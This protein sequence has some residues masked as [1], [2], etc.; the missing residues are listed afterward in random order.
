MNDF[1]QKVSE[2]LYTLREGEVLEQKN[3]TQYGK[4]MGKKMDAEFCMKMH[5]KQH[6]LAIDHIRQCYKSSICLEMEMQ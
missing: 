6:T 4:D 3:F 5:V 1:K 2:G